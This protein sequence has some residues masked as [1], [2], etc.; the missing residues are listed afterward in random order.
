[1]NKPGTRR[2][3]ET[4]SNTVS[5]GGGVNVKKSSKLAEGTFTVVGQSNLI[6]NK[7]S[8]SFSAEGKQSSP[9]ASSSQGM[10]TSP[11][12]EL[13]VPLASSYLHF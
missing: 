4:I 8:G 5:A 11:T 9:A 3:I 2:V 7:L 12:M 6:R 10:N 13:N 1:M